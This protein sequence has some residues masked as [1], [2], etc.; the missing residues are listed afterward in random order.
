MSRLATV[1]PHFMLCVLA[2]AGMSCRVYDSELLQQFSA[3]RR[4]SATSVDTLADSGGPVIVPGCGNGR[5]EGRE[6]CDIAIAQG[7]EGACPDGCS[8]REGCLTQ[9]LVGQRCGT[10]CAPIEITQSVPGDGCC[11]SGATSETDSDCSATCG[12][13]LIEAGET[14]DP[15]ESCPTA[16]S[17]RTDKACT[18]AHITGAA[19]TCSARCQELPVSTCESGDGCCPDRCSAEVDSDCTSG[20]ELDRPSTTNRTT[21][22]SSEAGTAMPDEPVCMSGE[23]CSEQEQ[24]EECSAVHSGGACHAC[25]CAY[26]AAEVARCESITQESGGCARVVECALENRCQ[27]AECLCGDNTTSCQNRPLGPCLWEIRELAGS[28][29]YLNIWWTASTPGTPL[30][31]ALALMQCRADHCAETCGL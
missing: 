31:I 18:V 12:N 6:H 8:L 28:R 27:G 20:D 23:Q 26:C 17:C 21:T 3:G 1:A 14:C 4:T 7:Q 5:V 10:R 24:A 16:E 9:E 29:D 30:A 22:T 11:P 2:L 25:D 15:P 13:G 19:S